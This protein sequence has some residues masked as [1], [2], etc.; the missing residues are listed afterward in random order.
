[1]STS[2]HSRRRFKTNRKATNTHIHDCSLS[3]LCNAT[4]IRCV[5]CVFYLPRPADCPFGEG[6]YLISKKVSLYISELSV[7][8]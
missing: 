8:N 3:M 7:G 5:S 4:S 2:M 6:V 1:M